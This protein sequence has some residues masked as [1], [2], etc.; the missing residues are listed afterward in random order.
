MIF[1]LLWWSGTEPLVF[2]RYSCTWGI[3][4][5]FF[6][7]GHLSLGDGSNSRTVQVLSQDYTYTQ[8]FSWPLNR[9]PSDSKLT[10]QNTKAMEYKNGRD[11]GKKMLEWSRDLSY[12]LNPCP[13]VLLGQ[14]LPIRLQT[15]SFYTFIPFKCLILLNNSKN[16]VVWSIIKTAKGHNNKQ[17]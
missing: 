1:T 17:R 2:L 8:W 11:G 3:Q 7:A 14:H 9:C 4:N 13:F 12:L 10:D 16:C 15:G 5:D 6:K